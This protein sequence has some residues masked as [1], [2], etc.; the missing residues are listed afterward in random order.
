MIRSHWKVDTKVLDSISNYAARFDERVFEI[1]QKAY[2]RLA[3][4]V[5]DELQQYPP[6]PPDSKYVRTYRL[7]NSWRIG[8]IPAT[9]GFTIEILNDARDERGVEYSKYVVGSLATVR[10]TALKAQAWMHK[11]RWPLAA[12]TVGAWY[13]L[14]MEAYL[15]E[16]QKELAN[17]GSTAASRRTYTR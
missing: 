9:G 15:E 12:D 3:D 14:F 10:A 16:F 7:R 4:D 6:P 2:E 1:G 11:G 8:I 17:Y 5:L 13:E